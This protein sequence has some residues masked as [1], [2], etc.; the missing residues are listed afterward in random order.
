MAV[1]LARIRAQLRAD[2]EAIVRHR[3][4]RQAAQAG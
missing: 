4:A 3:A 1:A 2:Y